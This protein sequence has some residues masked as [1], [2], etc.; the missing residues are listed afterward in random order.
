MKQ[1]V[2]V[3]GGDTTDTNGNVKPKLQDKIVS[4]VLCLDQTIWRDTVVTE[5]N[6]LGYVI[7]AGTETRVALN[8]TKAPYRC[9]YLDKV[10][11]EWTLYCFAFMLI[12]AGIL[13]IFNS[14]PGLAFGNLSG[15]GTGS[16]WNDNDAQVLKL[17]L[18]ETSI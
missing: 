2:V 8:L 17:C 16:T 12:L 4:E 11:D 6:V 15:T 14:F 3:P 18:R 7:F 1:K 5:G 13:A 10:T 9:G